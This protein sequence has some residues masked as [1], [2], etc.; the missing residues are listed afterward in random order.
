MGLPYFSY[1]DTTITEP[2]SVKNTQLLETSLN[3]L[4]KTLPRTTS[5]RA[6]MSIYLRWLEAHRQRP[7]KFSEDW[8]NCIMHW[9]QSLKSRGFTKE[10]VISEL[11]KWRTSQNRLDSEIARV[12][13][14][15]RD[16]ADAFDDVNSR[17]REGRCS[18]NGD[19]WR[20]NYELDAAIAL[21]PRKKNS[22]DNYHGPPPRNYVCNR[23]SIP[24]RSDYDNGLTSRVRS[25]STSTKK[26]G[27]A[28]PNIKRCNY[29]LQH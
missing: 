23:C 6:T 8:E 13:A 29:T 28:T 20:P 12:P 25:D 14:T 3:T 15:S 5:S 7:T 26:I 18:K 24:G 17:S 10:E 4:S 21:P 27:P 16:I 1:H 2:D 22:G 19:S 11:R 9:A